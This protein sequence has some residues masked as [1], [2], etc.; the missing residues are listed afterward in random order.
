[1]FPLII[2]RLFSL[3][4]VLLENLEEFFVSSK[5]I[6]IRVLE[7]WNFFF[8]IFFGG[9]FFFFFKLNSSYLTFSFSSFRLLYF[10]FF[11][12]FIKFL[13]DSLREKMFLLFTLKKNF[14]IRREFPLFSYSFRESSKIFSNI[15]FLF[16]FFFF[17]LFFLSFL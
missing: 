1:M 2:L 17:F 14:L 9:G 15:F 6:R 10:F 12:K 3:R 16:L 13:R 11:N 4:G 8:L 5:F 7:K